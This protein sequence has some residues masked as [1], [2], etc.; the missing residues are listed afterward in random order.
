MSWN[1]CDGGS[2]SDEGWDGDWSD[3]EGWSDEDG[4]YDDWS[5]EDGWYDD[6]ND[7]GGWYD[8]WSDEGGWNDDWSDEGGWNDDWSDN[9][10]LVNEWF[11]EDFMISLDDLKLDAFILNDF[12]S[13]SKEKS[14]LSWLISTRLSNND[15]T[16]L[17]E[18]SIAFDTIHLGL[19]IDSEL[20]FCWN[21]TL[22]STFISSILFLEWIVGF[23]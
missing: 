15:N 6:W 22:L 17:I 7:E 11:T 21:N 19:I 14:L 23:K 4:W 20:L 5:D 9:D 1:D 3:D 13:F 2:W 18:Q 16:S 12:I 10:W 8:D